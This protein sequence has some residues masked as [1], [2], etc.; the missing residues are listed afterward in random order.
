MNTDKRSRITIICVHLCSSV[1]PFLFA[2]C[3]KPNPANIALRKENQTFREQIEQLNR[4]HEADLAT[5]TSLRQNIP[6]TES[7][8]PERT[9]RLFTTHGIRMKRLT[10]GADLDPSAPG[11]EA[12]KVYL[13]PFDEDGHPLKAAGS[14]VVDM[15]DLAASDDTRLGRCEFDTAAARGAWLSGGLLYE[16]VLTCPFESPP[17]H[18][19]VTVRVTFTDELTR[20]Q[21]TEQKVVKVALASADPNTAASK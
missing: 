21:F 5:I 11:D 13:E 15:F 14:V 19:E 6:T 16:Y 1:V 10:G 20:R 2:G 17:R 4:Q 12:V 18:R 9:S 7:L 3:A 8:P